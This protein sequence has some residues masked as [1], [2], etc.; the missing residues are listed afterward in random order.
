[1]LSRLDLEIIKECIRDSIMLDNQW[2][3]NNINPV[4]TP[5]MRDKIDRKSEVLKRVKESLY[6]DIL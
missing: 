6:H 5:I 1:M 3:R 4:D 2:M